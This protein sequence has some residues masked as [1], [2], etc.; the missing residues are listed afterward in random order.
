M[1]GSAVVTA[2]WA[3]FAPGPDAPKGVQ[4]IDWSAA[5]RRFELAWANPDVLFNGVP[6]IACE[7]PDTCHAYGM[8]RYGDQYEY[9][10][11]D[12]ETGDVTGRVMLGTEDVVLDQGNNHAV[13]DDGSIVYAGKTRMVRVR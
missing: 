7:A 4:R 8:G 5:E 10:S 12:F 3:G 11:L 1:L 2:R 13:A 9:A 6:T